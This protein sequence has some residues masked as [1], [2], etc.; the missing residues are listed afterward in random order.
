MYVAFLLGMHEQ[1]CIAELN[2]RKA[3]AAFAVRREGTPQGL[4]AVADARVV[5]S[6][7]GMWM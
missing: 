4:I 7:F 6:H 5:L 1:T 3:F 2:C